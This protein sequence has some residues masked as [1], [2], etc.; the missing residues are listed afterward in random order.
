MSKKHV[1]EMETTLATLSKGDL[2]EVINVLN[3]NNIVLEN[4]NKALKLELEIK[5]KALT[6]KE[7]DKD[8]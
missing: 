5:D 2:I 4:E 7:I 1:N 6:R 3:G 8:N